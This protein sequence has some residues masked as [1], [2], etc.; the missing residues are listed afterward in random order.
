MCVRV[1]LVHVTENKD[2]YQ[3]LTEALMSLSI[4][5][6]AGNWLSERLLATE[7]NKGREA[8]WQ[9]AARGEN[10]LGHLSLGYYY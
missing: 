8:E 6:L 9:A 10:H 4:P 7:V 1:G 5:Y 2:Q 3:A